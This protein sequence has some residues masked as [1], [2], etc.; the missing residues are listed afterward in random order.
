MVKIALAPASSELAREIIDVLVATGKHEIVA[1]VRRDPTQFPSLPG[2]TWVQTDYQDKAELVRLFNG[3]EVVLSFIP[4][5]LDI[6]NAIQKRL[7]D[8]S[9]E[10]GVKRFAPSEWSCGTQLESVLGAIP[11]YTGKVE[12]AQYLED[13]NQ[14]KKVIEYT[15]FH[16]GGFMNYLAHPHKSTSHVTTFNFLIDFES[17]NA[18]VIEG[19]LDSVVALTTVQDIAGVVARAVEFK[20]EWPVIGGIAGSRI[21]I[22]ELLKLGDA[23]GRPFKIQWLKGEDLEAIEYKPEIYVGVDLRNAL[24]E[25][26][27]KFLQMALNG[28]LLSM[29]RGIY[30]V[31]DEWNKLL[32]DYKFT[33]TED[34]IKKYWGGK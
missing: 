16:P 14:D 8:A 3:V 19:S 32:P 23:I 15:R 29:S 34:F 12:V 6:G 25:Q 22:G 20:G 18:Q 7:I 5:H 9:I 4:V 17:Q 1:L 24:P 28:M 11:W 21:T 27:G 13:L 31:T 2:V 33:Q 10:A 30:D 26:A